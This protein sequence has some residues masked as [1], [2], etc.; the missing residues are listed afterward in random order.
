MLPFMEAM[1]KSSQ[2]K[3][4][5]RYLNLYFGNGVSLPPPEYKELR[6]DWHWFPHHE[7]HDYKMTKVLEPLTEHRQNMTILGGL[8][9][10][11]SRMLVGHHAADSWLTGADVGNEYQNTISLDQVVAEHFKNETRYPFMNL[12][13]DG[14]TGLEVEQPLWLL[15]QV[16]D[17]FPQ[18]T[19]FVKYLKGFLE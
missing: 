12:S 11:R 2:K 16:G 5:L 15:M 9:H 13:T 17:Q 4:P 8:S 14:G 7:G 10:P 1:S 6:K 18:K 19:T 3:K